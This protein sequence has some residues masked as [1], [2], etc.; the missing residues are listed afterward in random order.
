M[1]PP[2][3]PTSVEGGIGYI[4][5][6]VRVVLDIPMWPDPE[7]E[8]PF[9]VIK[10]INLNA[11]PALRVI[12][13]VFPFINFKTRKSTQK[14]QPKVMRLGDCIMCSCLFLFWNL[15]GASHC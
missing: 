12:Y 9:T 15:I 13:S 7:F 4:R 2:E 5:Y 6:M 1:L 11:I 10:A 3:L 8:E 14:Q